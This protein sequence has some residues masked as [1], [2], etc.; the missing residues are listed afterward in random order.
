MATDKTRRA[1][2][3]TAVAHILQEERNRRGLSLTAVAAG[4]GLSRQMISF[5]EQ[6]TRNPTLDTV[7]R[8][9]DA[10]GIDFESVLKRAKRKALK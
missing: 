5:V 4:A 8:I 9:C 3:C 1:Q 10:I 6:E 2:I 7:L